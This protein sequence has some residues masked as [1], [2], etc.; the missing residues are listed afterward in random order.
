M[1][2]AAPRAGPSP[3]ALPLT[4]LGDPRLRLTDPR[5]IPRAVP[6]IPRET[7]GTEPE[8]DTQDGAGPVRG[9][10]GPTGPRYLPPCLSRSLELGA[11]LDTA[12]SSRGAERSGGSSRLGK[13]REP[14]RDACLPR[15]RGRP[16]TVRYWETPSQ[17]KLVKAHP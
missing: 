13:R 4:M 10:A 3:G 16:P 9:G 5:A 15:R 6:H 7:G 14:C 17:L 12:S 2:A 8:G 11:V 1:P